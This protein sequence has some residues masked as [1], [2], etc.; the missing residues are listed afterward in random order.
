MMFEAALPSPTARWALVLALVVSI[1]GAIATG[2]WQ[3]RSA[4]DARP[5]SLPRLIWAGLTVHG[6]WLVPTVLALD[7]AAEPSLRVMFGVFAAAFWMRALAQLI[8][9]FGF[10][11]WRSEYGIFHDGFALV[12]LM[13]AGVLTREPQRPVDL[14]ASLLAM[15]MGALLTIDLSISVWRKQL[16]ASAGLDGH[17]YGRLA[18]DHEVFRRVR[19]ATW[20]ALLIF[21]P[22]LTF[23]QL[24][25]V[26]LRAPD[27]GT[28]AHAPEAMPR[29]AIMAHRGASAVAPEGTLPA[30]LVARKL[31]PDFVE[32]DVQRTR[33]G[34]LIAYH[35][36]DLLRTT[37]IATK[38]PERADA[39]PSELD[40]LA[41]ADLDAGSWFNDEHSGQAQ[42]AF[43]GLRI[44]RLEELVRLIASGP[45]DPPGLY[46][47]TKSPE[48]H[49]GVEAELVEL[50]GR[51][52]WLPWDGQP[53]QPGRKVVFQSF[54]RES[55]GKLRKLTPETPLVLLLDEDPE[56]DELEASFEAAEA[57]HAS[58]GISGRDWRIIAAAHADGRLVHAY[59]INSPWSLLGL[60]WVGVDGI[61]TDRPEMGLRFFGRPTAMAEELVEAWAEET[62]AD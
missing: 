23:G 28:L 26:G 41:L 14:I 51:L 49:P 61:F 35:D 27:R 37:D 57:L 32:I 20:V 15:W 40:W 16:I 62:Q 11:A 44:L 30:Y 47:E 39:S 4:G 7:T 22:T 24:L 59:T 8:L 54:S 12:V 52:G 13:V 43:V 48:R 19:S 34:V 42:D 50:L 9:R 1:L 6:L 3:R 5:V 60:W 29:P 25:H 18:P 2:L 46:I 55:L 53:A 21:L 10:D 58:L 17:G 38:I 56:E 33:D 36:D 45:E 31:H